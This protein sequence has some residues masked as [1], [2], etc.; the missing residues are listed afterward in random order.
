MVFSPT[1]PAA[2]HTSGAGGRARRASEPV[3]GR[4]VVIGGTRHLVDVV[5]VVPISDLPISPAGNTSTGPKKPRHVRPET[6]G[7]S[8]AREGG[9]KV[10][11]EKS[12]RGA[13]YT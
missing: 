9:R 5:L 4:T 12:K 8:A 2:A 11:R 3:Y 13:T 10:E 1:G 6:T 7:A